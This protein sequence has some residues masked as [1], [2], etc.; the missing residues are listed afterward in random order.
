MLQAYPA[1]S[2]TCE[3][4]GRAQVAV[5][6]DARERRVGMCCIAAAVTEARNWI[7]VEEAAVARRL[8]ELAHTT[9]SS[10]QRHTTDHDT[11]HPECSYCRWAEAGR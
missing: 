10:W 8:L 11:Y 1:E 4:C 2:P 9:K 7:A 6:R 5:Y 3:L